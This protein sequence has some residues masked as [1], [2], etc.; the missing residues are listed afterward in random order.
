MHNHKIAGFGFICACLV[1]FIHLP[2]GEASAGGA[3]WW[4]KE[5]F[6]R[7]VCQIAVPFFFC[8]S[9]YFLGKRLDEP[10]WWQS[11]VRKRVRSLF[12]PY[13]IWSALYLDMALSVVLAANIVAG[14][15]LSTNMLVDGFLP[16][17]VHYL[18][19]DF[20]ELPA[21]VPLWYVRA[22][23]VFVV[24]MPLYVRLF[25]I[26]P[27]LSVVVVFVSAVTVELVFAS[28]TPIGMFFHFG[29]PLWCMVYFMV[30]L[31]LANK[32]VEPLL[33]GKM[34]LVTLFLVVAAFM[35]AASLPVVVAPVRIVC[36]HC[37]RPLLLLFVWLVFP[38]EPMRLVPL[39]RESFP[40]FL[41]HPFVIFMSRFMMRPPENVVVC[42]AYG[43]AVIF[44]SL[45]LAFTMRK[46]MPKAASFLF[47][48]R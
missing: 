39:A 9:G 18:G 12:I 36:K 47:G 8:V 40:V 13:L 34:H 33:L 21:L 38:A 14:R 44:C 41:L 20:T 3:L 48:G 43:C 19:L 37:Y 4:F 46:C 2:L 23:L 5:L 22:L 30:G 26:F 32:I 15:P 45:V 6:V 25:R 7:G 28:D 35:L 31:L 10:G 24:A 11:A 27:K 42:I 1:V 17:M 16:A 29:I